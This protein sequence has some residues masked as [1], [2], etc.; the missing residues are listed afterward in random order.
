MGEQAAAIALAAVAAQEA[1]VVQTTSG[2]DWPT[3]VS[4]FITIG[5]AVFTIYAYV[6]PRLEKKLETRLDSAHDRT[7]ISKELTRDHFFDRYRGRLGRFN[8]ML[9]GFFGKKLLGFQALDRC[10][11][12]ALFYPIL[13]M[14]LGWIFGL[15]ITVGTE[16]FLPQGWAVW[17][18]LLLLL[19]LISYAGIVYF[20]FNNL[21]RI[22]DGIDRFLQRAFGALAGNSLITRR[23]IRL[24]A[25]AVAVAGAVAVAVAVAVAFAGAGAGA[26][27][28][29]FAVAFAVAD[30]GSPPQ[31]VVLLFFCLLPALNALL[32]WFSWGLTRF[33]LRSAAKA[34]AGWR[35]ARVLFVDL[36]IDLLAAFLFLAVLAALLPTGFGLFD[37]VPAFQGAFDWR[38]LLLAARDD[39][40]GAGLP[41]T[42]ML[43]STLVPTLL[44]LTLGFA[45]LFQLF[46]TSSPKLAA[47]V[48]RWDGIKLQRRKELIVQR[49][50][51][52]NF[53]VIP[54]FVAASGVVVV[55]GAIITLVL[56]RDPVLMLYGIADKAGAF[57]AGLL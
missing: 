17:Q 10:L 2:P 4:L 13:F 6:W 15:H 14:I 51:A 41:V 48:M 33:L 24:T 23:V 35:G 49:L 30:S 3:L 26:V 43:L 56:H 37:S 7:L 31:I 52:R 21:D 46:F 42:L 32:D 29:A 18:R 54:G 22:I 20:L 47:Q 28:F 5:M 50:L 16:N 38:A 1:P 57:A 44:H 36:A 25:F 27:A 45:A 12:I 9:D 39:P 53:L 11:A 8:Q 40:F 19:G 34:K 55:F